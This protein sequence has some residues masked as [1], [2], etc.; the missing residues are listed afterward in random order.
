MKRW[1]SF[2][3][4]RTENKKVDKFLDDIIKIYKKHKLSLGH[5]DSQGSFLIE[6]ISEDNI[7]WIKGASISKNYYKE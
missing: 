2:L 5:E 6:K 3:K 7:E 1:D 4:I